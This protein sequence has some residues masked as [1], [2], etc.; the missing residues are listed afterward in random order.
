MKLTRR[1]GLS[2]AGALAVAAGFGRGA[3]AQSRAQTLRQVT[4]NTINTLDPSVPGATREAFGLSVNVYDRLVSFGRKQTPSGNWVFDPNT[5]RPELAESYT[6]S[7][8]GLLIT[9]KLRKDAV[10]HDGTP[11]TAEDVK[12]SLDRAVSAKSLAPAQVGTGSIT[13][14]EQF[15]IVDAS[16]VTVTLDKPDR[17]ALPNLCTLYVIMIN[18]KVA[19]QHAT[20]EDPWALAWLKENTAGGGAYIVESFKPGESVILKRNE[21][22]KGG[23]DGKLPFFQ[24]IITQTVPDAT[25]R[26]NLIQ[27]GDADISIDLQSSDVAGMAAHSAVQVVSTPQFNAFT[28]VVFNLKMKPF[29]DVRVR[30]AVAAALPYDDMFKAAIFGRGAPL[31][32]GKWTGT[33]TT[34]EFPQPMPFK[35][36]IALAKKLLA[37]AGLPNGFSTTFTYNVGAAQVGDPMSALIKESLGKAGINVT[38]AKE[39]DAQM[40][41]DETNK[42]LAFFSDTSIAW[43]PSTDYFF[44]NFF[45]G[46]QRWNYSGWNNQEIVSV[47]QQARFEQDPKKYDA[48][49]ERLI[50]IAA[51]EVP[52]V[53]LWQ[54][55]QDATLAANIKNYTYWY[56]RQVDYRDLVRV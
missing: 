43:L 13:K 36:D 39:P 4:G 50:A 11:V 27:R 20:A 18:S 54:P 19:K 22:W 48:L 2:G 42:A 7:P 47:A 34:S 23:V 15:K 38:I 44:R 52:V 29:D 33:P 16:T 14:P 10:W 28:M 21:K 40:S 25:T 8:D 49:A 37:E 41:T 17:L 31:F 51:D 35:T 5:V 45:T 53:M 1:Q 12:W 9:F 30:R 56:H 26:A 46:D 24:R 32:G 6:I 3:H 55:N